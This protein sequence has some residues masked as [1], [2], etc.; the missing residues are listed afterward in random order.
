MGSDVCL[1]SFSP[2]QVS[3]T[4]EGASA[5]QPSGRRAWMVEL[6]HLFDA[7]CHYHAAPEMKGILA[8]NLLLIEVI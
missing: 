1:L 2:T 7:S 8:C 6:L 3:G 4:S 5:V